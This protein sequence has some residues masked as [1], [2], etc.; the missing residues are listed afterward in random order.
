MKKQKKVKSPVAWLGGKSRMVNKLIPMIPEHKTYVEPFGGGGSMLLAKLPSKIE[1]YNDLDSG[2][3]NFFRVLRNKVSFSELQRLVS[4]TPYSREEY[5]ECN[6]SWNT[7]EDFIDMAHKWFVVARMSFSG[8]FGQSFGY[9]RTSSSRGMAQC[10]SAYLGAIERLPE[11]CERLLR[12]LIE[13]KDALKLIEQFDSE[14]TFF[15]LDPPYV[16]STRNPSAGYRHE[17][18]DEQHLKLIELVQKLKGKVMI[19]GYVNELYETL[20]QKGWQRIDFDAFLS[21]SGHTKNTKGLDS[22]RT[23]SVWLNYAI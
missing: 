17:M 16:L 2:I 8:M 15:Y 9:S 4:L 6:E 1:V 14:S 23:E 20:E 3:V 13:N 19:S 5:H 21:A 11:I 12:V 18:T 7:S 22:K 10:V